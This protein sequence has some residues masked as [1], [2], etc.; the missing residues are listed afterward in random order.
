MA[1]HIYLW[2]CIVS[3]RSDDEL[4]VSAGSC[5][6]LLG[7]GAELKPGGGGGDLAALPRHLLHHNQVRVRKCC[8]WMHHLI[9][10]HQIQDQLPFAEGGRCQLKRRRAWLWRKEPWSLYRSRNTKMFFWWKKILQQFLSWSLGC[11][12]HRG[13]WRR[14]GISSEVGGKCLQWWG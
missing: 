11:W 5:V 4:S 9:F 14:E 13:Q 12:A 1:S 7:R 2:I 8:W 10:F 6:S 3:G